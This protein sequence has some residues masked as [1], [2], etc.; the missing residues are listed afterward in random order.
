[1]KAIKYISFFLLL[2]FAISACKKNFTDTSFVSTAASAS[3]LSVMFNIT[4]D[5]TGLVTITP[6]GVGAVN[7][8]VFFGDTTTSS[9]NIRAGASVQHIYKE[10]NYQ[11]KIVAHDLKGGSTTLTQ[12]LVV[13]F[14]APQDLKVN[15]STTNLTVNVSATAKFATFFKIYFGDSTNIT[16]EP[17]TSALPGQTVSHTYTQ[18]GTYLVKVLAMSGGTE[19]TQYTDTIQVA[20]QIDLPVTFEDPNTN[21]T[22]SDFGGDVSTLVVD[23][24]DNNNHVMKVVKTAGAQVWAG[25]T[26][27]TALGFA[28]PIPLT[29][30]NKKMIVRV[31]SPA[32]GLDIK[33]KVDNHNNPNAGLSVETDVLTTVANQW[34]TLTFDFGQPAAGTPAFNPSNTYDLASIFFDFGNAGTGSIFYFDDVKMAPASLAQISLPVTFES[35]NVD[36]TVTDFGGNSSVLTVD[37]LNPSNHVMKST[38]TVGAQVWA[39]TTIG[40]PSGFAQPIPLTSAATKMSVKVFSPAAG[41]DVKLKLDNHANPNNG[42]SVETDV[43]TTVANQWETLIFD[44][45]QPASGTPAFNPSNTYDLASIFFDFGN[46]GTGAVFY[47]DEV[48]FLSQMNLPVNFNNPDMDPTVTDFGNNTSTLAPDPANTGLQVMKTVKPN[49]AKTWAGTTMGTP[50]GFASPIPLT[51][52]RTKM[53]VQVYSPAAGIP[54]LLKVEDHNNGNNYVQVLVNTTVANQWETLTFDFSQPQAGT[55]AWSAANTYDKCS[56]FFDF[57]NPGSGKI[58]YWNNVNIQ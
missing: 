56:I 14:L 52:S 30:A 6:N 16:P 10:G 37:P 27:G 29:N 41:I 7:Y 58:F 1:M 49:G 50:V 39:G 32:V 43:L 9:V 54:V 20:T 34:E 23:P 22:M 47:W 35:T 40:T 5:N 17:F 3:N 4:Q 55:P 13:S 46:A 11:V 36:Y 15:L 51:A 33:L 25:T 38:K 12:P 44:F 21:Y 26:I 42:L 18:A 28:H 2:V 45:S 24:V 8:D 48:H 57:N 19:T 31:Y 53:T